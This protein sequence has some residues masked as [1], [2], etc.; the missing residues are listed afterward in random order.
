MD[1]NFIR[2]PRNSG[3]SAAFAARGGGKLITRF[4]DTALR[5]QHSFPGTAGFAGASNRCAPRSIS[6]RHCAQ[7]SRN[8]GLHPSRDRLQRAPS[9]QHARDA[10]AASR[11]SYQ[12]GRSRGGETRPFTHV[13]GLPSY[14]DCRCAP[15][16]GT[17]PRPFQRASGCARPPVTLMPGDNNIVA[18]SRGVCLRQLEQ[19]L[20]ARLDHPPPGA[21][22][23]LRGPGRRAGHLD[24]L[25][26]APGLC[27]A[28]PWRMSSY[29][30][31]V[32]WRRWR[33]RW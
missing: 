11:P 18:D 9:S 29:G 2:G 15:A 20:H 1:L 23:M 7:N 3:M 16:W 33:C 10:G 21:W 27:M 6:S 31:G 12:R 4:P 25:V 8:R 30:V 28:T 32:R 13:G 24:A 14:F 5:G 26:G 22:L 17:S 19:F